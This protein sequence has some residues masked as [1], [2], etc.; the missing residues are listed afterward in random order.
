M[1]LTEMG[2][3]GGFFKAIDEAG[4]LRLSVD[5]PPIDEEIDRHPLQSDDIFASWQYLSADKPVL[6]DFDH[7]PLSLEQLECMVKSAQRV[8]G[9]I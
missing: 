3:L 9:M 4:L 7:D 5:E 6:I 2:V 8:H 1:T